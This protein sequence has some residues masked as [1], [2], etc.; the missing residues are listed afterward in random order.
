MVHPLPPGHGTWDTNPL[1]LLVTS[2][3]HH[4]RPV[5]TEHTYPQCSPPP[6][7]LISTGGYRRGW[8]ASHWN[9]FLLEMLSLLI[10]GL[11][12]AQHVKQR[13]DVIL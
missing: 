11:I 13:H 10:S 4:W 3:G 1:P 6:P 5:Q 12:T 2:G 8:Y 9:A 7:V